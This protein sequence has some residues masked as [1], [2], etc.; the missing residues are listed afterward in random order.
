MGISFRYHAGVRH[1][2]TAFAPSMTAGASL[3]V[4]VAISRMIIRSLL[5][6]HA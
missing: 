6:A 3:I 5:A 2:T 1:G 4:M